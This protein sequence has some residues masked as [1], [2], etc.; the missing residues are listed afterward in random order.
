MLTACY[1]KVLL[2]IAASDSDMRFES[3]QRSITTYKY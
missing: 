1:G 3:P 2:L